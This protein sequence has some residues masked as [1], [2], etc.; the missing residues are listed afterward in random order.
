M[1]HFYLQLL[2][3][4]GV[5][6]DAEGFDTADV[7]AARG[8]SRRAAADVIADEIR[9]VSDDVA[10]SLCLDNFAGKRLATIPVTATVGSF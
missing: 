8:Y 9:Q 6:H 5:C 4:G 2:D 1:A 7:I 10:F 3:A